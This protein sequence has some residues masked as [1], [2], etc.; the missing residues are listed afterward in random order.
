[1]IIRRVDSWWFLPLSL[2]T[3]HENILNAFTKMSYGWASNTSTIYTRQ[4]D[5]MA[6]VHFQRTLIRKDGRSVS[7]EK[8]ETRLDMCY[9]HNPQTQAYYYDCAV[10]HETSAV[11]LRSLLLL[12]FCFVFFNSFQRGL[13][14]ISCSFLIRVEVMAYKFGYTSSTLLILF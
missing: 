13:S 7:I 2:S 12:L 1:M 3:R 4:T 9:V 11:W 6:G 10:C 14:S 8:K 5:E